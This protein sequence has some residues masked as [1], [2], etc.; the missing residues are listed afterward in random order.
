[1]I[2]CPV[3][4][5]MEMYAEQ[6]GKTRFYLPVVARSTVIKLTCP[7]NLIYFDAFLFDFL[8]TRSSLSLISICWQH[9]Y[10]GRSPSATKTSLNTSKNQPRHLSCDNAACAGSDISTAC[11]PPSLNEGFI[12][13]IQ[14]S[15]D[16]K[17]KEVAP[18]L[19]GLI[20]SSMISIL[21]TSTPPMLPRWSLSV[22]SGRPL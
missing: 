9:L 20:Q 5:T 22:P 12:S 13:S 4:C 19:G 15:M 18:K 7:S 2:Q 21:L 6:G 16:G 17:D 1:M 11:H 3:N 10:S 14:T 8:P